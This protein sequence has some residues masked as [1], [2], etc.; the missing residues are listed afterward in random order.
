[1]KNSLSDLNNYLFEQ[2]DRLGDED[3]TAEQTEAE[4]RRAE[5]MCKI[6]EQIVRNGELQ[7][8]VM[9]HMDEYG[10]ERK[11]IPAVLEAK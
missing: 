10:Y 3:M 8:K 7:F 11:A 5:A 2:L 1:M 9:Q 4:I 6:G